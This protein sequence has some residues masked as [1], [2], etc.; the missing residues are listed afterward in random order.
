ME[1]LW[2]SSIGEGPFSRRLKVFQDARSLG[3]GRADRL[4]LNLGVPGLT[5]PCRLQR[6]PELHGGS[7]ESYGPVEQRGDRRFFDGEPPTARF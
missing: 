4:G 1:E 5:A 2:T 7:R 3:L 6:F